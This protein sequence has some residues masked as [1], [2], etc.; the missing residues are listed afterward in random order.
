MASPR[1]FD[2]R[3]FAPLAP[4]APGVMI[5]AHMSRIAEE[6]LRFFPLRNGFD[7]RVFLLEPLPHQSL[8]A[9]LRSVQRL[10][11]GGAELRQQPPDR[12]RAQRNATLGFDQRR[13]HFACPQRER[14]FKLQRV[15]LCHNLVNPL[16]GASVQ[17]RW[18]SKK[19]FCLQRSPSATPILRQPPVHRTGIDPQGSRHNLGALASLYATHRP[20]AHRFQ[21]RVIQL[22]R[23]IWPHPIIESIQMLRV[24]KKMNLLMDGLIE[25]SAKAATRQKAAAKPN[26][27]LII[28]PPTP[29]PANREVI[30]QLAAQYRL[31]MIAFLKTFAAEGGLMTYG[32]QLSDIWQRSASFVD[33]ILSTARCERAARCWL[34]RPRMT[35]GYFETPATL[36]LP[37]RPS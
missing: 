36:V 3:R 32:S 2:N 30:F 8:V 11:A 24:Y 6:N 25:G 5:R 17:F 33:R 7:L 9:F 27:G 19:G 28:L 13:Y 1:G 31:P 22:A 29:T 35:A 15:L 37:S 20:H 34:F 21:R 16:Q 10:L 26:G 23:I 4:G 12:I 18:S 14:E